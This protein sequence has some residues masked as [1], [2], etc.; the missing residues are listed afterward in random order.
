MYWYDHGVLR[1]D[2]GEVR[3]TARR[4]G[5]KWLGTERSV[6]TEQHDYVTSVPI[7]KWLNKWF[8]CKKIVA[9]RGI[10]TREV[11]AENPPRFA[12]G[13]KRGPPRPWSFN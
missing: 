2:F 11:K 5:I 4:A 1:S 9:G 13:A 3:R 10:G 7:V 12:E 8:S 6:P